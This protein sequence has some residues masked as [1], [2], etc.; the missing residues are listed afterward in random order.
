MWS[1]PTCVEAFLLGPVNQWTH[2]KNAA[3]YICWEIKQAGVCYRQKYAKW[4]VTDVIRS[5]S[6]VTKA[7]SCESDKYMV[8]FYSSKE[9]SR[10]WSLQKT[11]ICAGVMLMKMNER[12][13]LI[14]ISWV[15][16]F[17]I[18]TVSDSKLLWEVSA[19]YETV[20]KPFDLKQANN[21]IRHSIFFINSFMWFFFIFYEEDPYWMIHLSERDEI[22][23]FG[24]FLP[25][26][27]SD[28]W[29]SISLHQ[30]WMKL[31]PQSIK[32]KS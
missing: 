14:N 15:S 20:L 11:S 9:W 1:W 22:I 12:E 17:E 28:S 23:V 10:A 24:A 27:D 8:S 29:R 2:A 3:Q 7:T 31:C 13:R 25:L 19:G 5:F 26:L 4:K 21:T 16:V 18:K 32:Y 6:T 30:S